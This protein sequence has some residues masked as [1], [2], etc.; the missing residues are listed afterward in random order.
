MPPRL[1]PTLLPLLL[2]QF[3]L[4]HDLSGLLTL[5]LSQDGPSHGGTNKSMLLS[6][7]DAFLFCHALEQNT[8]VG[9][10]TSTQQAKTSDLVHEIK[11]MHI[12]C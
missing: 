12:I 2:Y 3:C 5:F 8:F 9:F 4:L 6:A 11:K 1:R 10:T 7:R